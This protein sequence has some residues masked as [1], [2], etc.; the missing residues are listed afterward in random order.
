MIRC[1]T[2]KS[3]GKVKVTFV[4]PTEIGGPASVVGDFNDWDP[5]ATR[6]RKRG[7]TLTASTTVEA[8]RRY[9]FRYLLKD[10]RWLNDDAAHA[11]EPGQFGEENSILDLTV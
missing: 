3:G 11:Y 4:L 9:A 6:L 10:G 7:D 1:D 2:A 5:S 8:G